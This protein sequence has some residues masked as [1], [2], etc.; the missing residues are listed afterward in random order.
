MWGQPSSAVQPSKLDS[1]RLRHRLAFRV[2]PEANS[3]VVAAQLAQSKSTPQ[4]SEH[5]YGLRRFSHSH[6]AAYLSSVL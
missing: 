2:L 5:P 1:L 3:R 4:S 6:G